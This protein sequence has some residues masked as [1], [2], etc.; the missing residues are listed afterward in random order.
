MPDT[1]Q[2]VEPTRPVVAKETSAPVAGA[3][4]T[5]IVALKLPN[6]LVLQL[7]KEVETWEASFA[8]GRTVKSW[9]PVL[10]RRHVLKG[11]AQTIEMQRAGLIPD[12]GGY[13]LTHGVPAD[14]WNQWFEHNKPT[15][16][17]EGNPLI[18]NELIAA[19]DNETDA[20]VWCLAHSATRSGLERI[21]P[22]HP[23]LHTGRDLDR[24]RAR[25]QLGGVSEVQRGVA[26]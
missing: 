26:A 18:V 22:E 11:N 7:Q 2:T 16:D 20:M 8:G 1:P 10:G 19:F 12:T 23:E 24:T 14:I 6:G 15:G 9:K 3:G 5:K 17:F 13:A 4:T 21:D 25:N